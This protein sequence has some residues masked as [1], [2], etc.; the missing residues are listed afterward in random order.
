MNACVMLDTLEM[1][2]YVHQNE[3]VVISHL[4][5]TITLNAPPQL[6]AINVF[7]IQVG[8]ASVNL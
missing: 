7:A 5:V 3:T 1:D 8:H 6:Q 2:F 4:F